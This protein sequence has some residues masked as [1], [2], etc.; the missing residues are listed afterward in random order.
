MLQQGKPLFDITLDVFHHHDGVVHHDADGEHQ[1]E[2]TQRVEREAK[3]VEDAERA[4]HGNRDG[5]QRDDRRAPGLQEQD[6][7]QHNKHYRFQQG[8]HHRPDR[9][10]HENRWVVRCRPLHVFREARGQLGHLGAHGVRQIDSVGTR[11]LED[12]DPDR[13]FVVQLGAQG[14]AA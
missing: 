14:I 10:A 4:H 2:Q 11:G 1:P 9:V 13:V 3:Q 12:T 8:L 5:N 7:H 6:H